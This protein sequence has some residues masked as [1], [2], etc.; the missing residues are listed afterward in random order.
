VVQ[1][2]A[3]LEDLLLDVIKFLWI[4]FPD[5][6]KVPMIEMAPPPTQY[7][8]KNL[9]R[10]RA[11]AVL[12]AQA[13]IDAF[14]E[15]SAV[16]TFLLSLYLVADKEFSF[17]LAF[18]LLHRRKDNPI[19]VQWLTD[20]ENSYIC[21]LR[22]GMR[23]GLIVKPFLTQYGPYF[24]RFVMAGVPIWVA[25]GYDHHW[26]AAHPIDSFVY[27]FFPPPDLLQQT[28]DRFAATREVQEPDFL[29]FVDDAQYDVPVAETLADSW[30]KEGLSVDNNHDDHEL[31]R[32][33]SPNPEDSDE[34]VV[35]SGQRPG[36]DWEEFF[37]R[38]DRQRL[39][40]LGSENSQA[41]QRRES[42]EREAE[43]SGRPSKKSK[44]FEWTRAKSG[45]WKRV[46]IASADVQYE[47]EGYTRRQ[48]R[49][50]GHRN[51]WDLC[52]QIPSHS[53]GEEG[54]R[55]EDLDDMDDPSYNFLYSKAPANP[56]APVDSQPTVRFDDALEDIVFP[57]VEATGPSFTPAD[58]F[59]LS[60]YLLFW[61]G[62][63]CQD[64]PNW[65]PHLHAREQRLKAENYKQVAERLL[66]SSSG[67]LDLSSS[68]PKVQATID[69]YNTLIS[70]VDIRSLP[71]SW[72][73][74]LDS[75]N[76]ISKFQ[77]RFSTTWSFSSDG[78]VG[79][80]IISPTMD[81]DDQTRWRIAT[82][83][84]TVVL[85][86]YR[87][88]WRTMVEVALGLLEAGVEF[89]TVLRI[90]RDERPGRLPINLQLSGLGFR[91]EGYVPTAADLRAYLDRLKDFLHSPMGRAMRMR[92][93]LVGRIAQEFVDDADVLD[94]PYTKTRTIYEPRQSSQVYVDD[95][96]T[97]EM[98]SIV[99]GVYYVPTSERGP[100]KH[101]SWFP[102]ESVWL[103]GG[104]AHI[105]WTPDAE[106]WYRGRWAEIR[107][108]GAKV[109]TSTQWKTRVRR[110]QQQTS[111]AMKNYENLASAYVVKYF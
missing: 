99:C 16:V 67:P 9:H 100:M 26:M 12:S 66:Q 45:F 61:H 1:S 73:M 105:S 47:I 28:K 111:K 40:F 36:E 30:L 44:V 62:F 71:K 56:S 70:G 11:D 6:D 88:G 19:S 58:I 52:R 77:T 69:F 93:G 14:S 42:R 34:P 55:I 103:Q 32:S 82:K 79:C 94:G 21:D 39:E 17:N 75:P 7:A 97:E 10:T 18:D 104:Y 22:L 49:F 85:F 65:H 84:A 76:A 87:Q 108:G 48:C 64:M 37:E 59:P 8:Y 78:S 27:R 80:F 43:K 35:G 102:K 54:G 24:E 81:S 3:L 83:S 72:D 57:D 5:A 90:Q 31:P 46:P 38:M 60:S 110:Y 63:S 109:Y 20:L 23:A 92:G 95:D 89:S 15:L 96:V 86:I 2:W 33:P 91:P 101:L 53:P 68:E 13:S 106:R 107:D 41:K 25:W 29:K 50:M 74:S 98:L 51:E 4:K